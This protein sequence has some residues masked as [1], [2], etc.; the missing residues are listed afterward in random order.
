[1]GIVVL[2][3]LVVVGQFGNKEGSLTELDTGLE[4]FQE[5]DEVPAH[6][7]A[8]QEIIA[9]HDHSACPSG[10]EYMD[11]ARAPT[12]LYIV[13]HLRSFR[14]FTSKYLS[15]RFCDVGDRNLFLSTMVTRAADM[16]VSDSEQR[17]PMKTS[18]VLQEIAKTPFCDPFFVTILSEDD[19]SKEMPPWDRPYFTSSGHQ[20]VSGGGKF[21]SSEGL[22]MDMILRLNLI[23]LKHAHAEGGWAPSVD[24]RQCA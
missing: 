5:S 21:K 8:T 2:A 23:N 4:H 14:N 13:G 3:A 6:P 12:V 22:L 10:F 9:L 15:Q 20:G 24:S 7:R 18:A 16:L 11:R 1:M 19:L 17:T